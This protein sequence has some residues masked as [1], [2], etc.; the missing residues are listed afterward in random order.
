MLQRSM[1]MGLMPR[2]TKVID[3]HIMYCHPYNVA[4]KNIYGPFLFITL[5]YVHTS[6]E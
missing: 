6:Y 2:S 5:H 1:I 4:V 3:R